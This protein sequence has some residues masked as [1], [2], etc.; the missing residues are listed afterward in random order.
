MGRRKKTKWTPYTFQELAQRTGINLVYSSV[1]GRHSRGA[2]PPENAC[3]RDVALDAARSLKHF[4]VGEA[5]AV[6]CLDRGGVRIVSF[7][8][9]ILRE[10][11]RT[12]GG[13]TAP[14]NTTIVG[15]IDDTIRDAVERSPTHNPACAERYLFSYRDDQSPLIGLTVLWYGG[16]DERPV[17]R[18]YESLS[19]VDFQLM[20]PCQDCIAISPLMMNV[21]RNRV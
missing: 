5:G 15:Y 14:A 17:P 4:N 10:T 16:V 9:K 2:F 21:A 18:G 19:S 8:G 7:S 1:R 11:N 6:G 20:A 12:L 13:L 3:S